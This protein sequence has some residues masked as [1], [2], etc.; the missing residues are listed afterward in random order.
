MAG[1]VQM[2][3]DEANSWLQK[4]ESL[5]DEL[6]VEVKGSAS[7]VQAVQ[8]S[9]SGSVVDELSSG[10]SEMLNAAS[11]LVNAFGNLASSIAE[12]VNAGMNAV[13]TVEG[14]IGKVLPFMG[15]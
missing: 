9:S 7:A 10:I 3:P 6:D 4:I 14:L 1:K 8:Q 12:V 13:E 15:L 5:N 11:N 2:N